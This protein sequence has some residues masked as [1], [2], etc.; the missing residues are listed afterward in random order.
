MRPS[1]LASWRQGGCTAGSPRLKAVRIFW[2]LLKNSWKRASFLCPLPLRVDEWAREV[3][4]TR[5]SG[6]SSK[7]NRDDSQLNLLFADEASKVRTIDHE[8]TNMGKTMIER[9]IE[10]GGI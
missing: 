4:R 7:V 1:S 5:S 6:L 8:L 3:K 9:L 2:P 10:A